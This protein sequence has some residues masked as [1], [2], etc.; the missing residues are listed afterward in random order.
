MKTCPNCGETLVVKNYDPENSFYAPANWCT[1]CK[2]YI[3]D[4][5]DYET[6]T[7]WKKVLKWGLIITGV[8]L[9]LKL[10]F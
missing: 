9:A 4:Q 6:K 5:E 8:S 3:T 7:T 10:I 2:E 1:Y